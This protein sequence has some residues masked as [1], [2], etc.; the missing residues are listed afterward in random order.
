MTFTVSNIYSE[1]HAACFY[2]WN[3]GLL[4]IAFGFRIW[5]FAKMY[6]HSTILHNV[7]LIFNTYSVYEDCNVLYAALSDKH[8]T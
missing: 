4:F 5:S 6:L 7:I 8:I 1:N 3:E 2:G